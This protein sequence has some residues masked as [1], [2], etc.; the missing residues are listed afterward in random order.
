MMATGFLLAAIGIGSGC[1]TYR[2]RLQGVELPPPSTARP[3]SEEG[4]GSRAGQHNNLGVFLE[5]QGDLEG[6]LRQYKLAQK[7]D[8][9]L[10]VAFVNAGNVNLQLG[11]L[12]GAVF[13]YREAL[14]LEPDQPRALN[15]LAWVYLLQGERPE[16]AVDLVKRALAADPLHPYLYLDSLGW[17]LWQ[18]GREEESL[19]VLKEAVETTPEE[20]AALLGE[21]HY[22]LGMIYLAREEYDAAAQHF[23]KSLEYY[24]PPGREREIEIY[25]ST[26]MPSAACPPSQWISPGFQYITR[27]TMTPTALVDSTSV[28][29][30]SCL[31]ATARALTVARAPGSTA[32]S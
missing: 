22:H 32:N 13:Y 28:E 31:P 15:N 21:A 18:A 26:A 7:Q 19:A 11:N 1:R 24:R 3:H 6:A 12:A 20:E 4:G 17:A 9:S 27:S 5:R 10:T 30:W 29:S 2:V 23:R 8:P 14:R 16:E 25:L